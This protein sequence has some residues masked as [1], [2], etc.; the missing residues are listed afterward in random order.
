MQ[1]VDV[2]SV[3]VWPRP[4]TELPAKLPSRPR[5]AT[6]IRKADDR[7]RLETVSN[8]SEPARVH[9]PAPISTEYR[10]YAASAV[11]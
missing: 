7:F 5:T 11:P 1:V 4:Q 2:L 3:L 9:K 6:Y 10:N 8:V